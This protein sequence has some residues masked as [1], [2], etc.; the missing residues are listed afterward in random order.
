MRKKWKIV[1][2]V[3][4]VLLVLF[5]GLRQCGKAA[6]KKAAALSTPQTHKVARGT[7]LSQVEITGEVQPET[8]V[9]IKSKVSGK[10]VKFYADENSY[11]ISGQTIDD[12]EPD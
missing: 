8:I 11:V 12:F 7:I 6:L 1:I 5:F 3:V 10:V 2:I 9:A 4:A